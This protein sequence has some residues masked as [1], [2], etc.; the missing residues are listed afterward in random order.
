M[1]ISNPRK[2]I[3]PEEF[4]RLVMFPGNQL[5]GECIEDYSKY[6]GDSWRYTQVTFFT[7]SN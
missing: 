5:H 7:Q 4:N 3:I 6:M 2:Q 1:I